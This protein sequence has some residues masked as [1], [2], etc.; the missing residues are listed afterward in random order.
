MET[1]ESTT[2]KAGDT[3]IIK[4]SVLESVRLSVFINII[5][6]KKVSGDRK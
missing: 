1:C 6:E 2:R 3:L 5:K 4:P